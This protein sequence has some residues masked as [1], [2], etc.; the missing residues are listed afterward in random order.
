M[1][2][3]ETVSHDVQGGA[4]RDDEQSSPSIGITSFNPTVD[5]AQ[6]GYRQARVRHWD[7]NCAQMRNVDWLG[8]VL[9]PAVDGGL[10]SPRCAGAVG[11]GTRLRSRG[12]AG[13]A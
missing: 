1:S 11:L 9:S 4:S 8:R 2:F 7:E 6:G 5:Q 13:D 3:D 10:A 12:S